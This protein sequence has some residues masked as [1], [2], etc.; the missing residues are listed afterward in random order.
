MRRAQLRARASASPRLL[1]LRRLLA[2]VEAGQAAARRAL[3]PD[4]HALVGRRVPVAEADRRRVRDRAVVAAHLAL[5]P[6]IALLLIERSAADLA[7][8]AVG[9][10]VAQ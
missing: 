6:Q 5:G 9:A 4:R 3:L 1:L 8:R 10:V 2:D 7:H